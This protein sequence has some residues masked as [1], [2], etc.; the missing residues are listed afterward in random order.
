MEAT[1][2][3]V[4]LHCWWEW[5]RVINSIKGSLAIPN[6]TTSVFTL[7]PNLHS[8]GM[9]ERATPHPR[10]GAVAERSYLT[11]KVRSV[12]V[13]CWSSHEEILHIQGKRNPSKTVGAK[14]G[15]QGTDRLKPQ[16]QTT[17]QSDHTDHS[18]CNSMELSHAVWGLP[19]RAR[20]GGE[21]WQNMVHWRREWQTTSV[22]LPWEPDEQYEKAKRQDTERGTPQV[23]RCPIC[24]RRSVEK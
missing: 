15:H 16:S 18:L 7:W 8:T 10:S 17:S 19:R 6:K 13:L 20:H 23:G 5:R 22:F 4:F 3:Q 11:S 14:R 1:G 24:Y 12:A 21:V 9:A 2:K